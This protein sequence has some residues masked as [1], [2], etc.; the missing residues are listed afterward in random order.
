MQGDAKVSIQTYNPIIL[1]NPQIINNYKVVP[2]RRN[3]AQKQRATKSL[4]RGIGAS[5]PQSRKLTRK[6]PL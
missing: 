2:Q 3:P 6:A 5:R 1:N 4:K